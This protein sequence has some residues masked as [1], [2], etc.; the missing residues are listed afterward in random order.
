MVETIAV[1]SNRYAEQVKEISPRAFI[2]WSPVNAAD[3][4]RFFAVILAMTLVK[5]SSY[6]EY[7]ST[8][9]LVSTPF[10]PTVMSR[11]RAIHAGKDLCTDE[12]L[13]P[14]KGRLSF[15]QYN[16]KKRS[17]FGVKLFLIEDCA[18]Q[19]VL[20]VLPYQGKSTQITDRSWIE[21]V[22][23]GGAAVLTLLQSF[24]DSGSRVIVDN[25]FHS[26]KLARMLKD[27][28]TYVLVTVQKRRKGMPKTV[29]MTRKLHKGEIETFSDGE[30]FIERWMDRREVLLLNTL[31]PHGMTESPSTNPTN[32]RLKPD[33]VLLYN[34]TMGGVD[35][36]DK[37]I[38]PNQ[39]LRKS[40]KWYKKV[41]FYLVEL[42][43]YNSMI[44]YNATQ[45]D[46]AGFRR[47]N[48]EAVVKSIIQNILIKFPVPRK[49][50]V[51]PSQSRSSVPLTSIHIP[52]RVLKENG[53][54]SKSNC[55][56]CRTKL[57][58]RTVTQFKCTG[59][60]K[61]LCI[62]SSVFNCFKFHHDELESQHQQVPLADRTESQN[63]EGQ[64][65]IPYDYNSL[66]AMYNTPQNDDSNANVDDDLLFV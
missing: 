45:N 28:L 61:R 48:Y 44:I 14:F 10:F 55:F 37:T 43:V 42:A 13:F 40:Y 33:T 38:K 22:G 29:R 39:S 47:L 50:R 66:F 7:W 8:D 3:I 34:K 60:E 24:L 58:K 64:N 23:F 4:W 9:S 63:T 6:K 26:L 2:S 16:P 20:D 53:Y 41:A 49:P 36:V 15:K 5:K 30:V 12:S 25:W 46:R 54:P 65:S 62:G 21:A 18:I 35:N 27:R 59:C 32:Q 17:R 11:D 51:R 56:H 52:E 57:G 19:F 31:M 1:E